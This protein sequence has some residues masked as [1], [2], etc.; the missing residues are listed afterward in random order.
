VLKKGGGHLPTRLIAPLPTKSLASSGLDHAY[1][2]AAKAA[3]VCELGSPGLELRNPQSYSLLH[4]ASE[5]FSAQLLSQDELRTR[6]TGELNRVLYFRSRGYSLVTC[7]AR[8]WLH[9]VYKAVRVTDGRPVAVKLL[10]LENFPKVVQAF[11]IEQD[12]SAYRFRREIRLLTRV[13]RLKGVVTIVDAGEISGVP[14][15]VCCWVEGQPLCEVLA[16][17][18]RPMSSRDKLITML[19]AARTVKKLHDVNIVHRDIA[20]D[21]LYLMPDNHTRII[22]FGMAESA[23]ENTGSDMQQYVRHD[24]FAVGLILC[25]IWLGRTWFS[26]GDPDLPRQVVYALRDPATLSHLSPISGIVERAMV[27]D[28]RVAA[29]ASG[30]REPYTTIA[31]F[32]TDLE[33]RLESMPY[34]ASEAV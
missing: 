34:P 29:R 31:D 15:H 23:D 25:E 21:H 7:H 10:T 18:R 27:C 22:D 11:G 12:H 6:Q 5:H 8:T 1:V 17:W 32:I 16:N 4:S 2:S 28:R 20:P 19:R 13:R 26:Y 14:Y 30:N 24:I 3:P 9:T 33:E